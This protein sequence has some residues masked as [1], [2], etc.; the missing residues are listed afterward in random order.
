MQ[1]NVI[2]LIVGALLGMVGTLGSQI[3][4]AKGALKTKRLELFYARKADAYKVLFERAADF[5]IDPKNVGKFL[6]F[7]AALHSAL[8]IAS[9]D[10]ADILDNPRRNGLHVSAVR[11]RMAENETEIQHI[12][13]H[14]WHQALEATKNAMRGDL[15]GLACGRSTV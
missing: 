15:S 13:M 6:Q 9:E 8:I 10:V 11:L 5:G 1:G 14:E 12:Q 4:A 7:Q 2:S 3:I